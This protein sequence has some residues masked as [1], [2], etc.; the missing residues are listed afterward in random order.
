MCR[1]HKNMALFVIYVAVSLVGATIGLLHPKAILAATDTAIASL[2]ILSGLSLAVSSL[3][4]GVGRLGRNQPNDP[5][6][7]ENLSAK[8][9]Q[10]NSNIS[11]RQSY[12]IK[13]FLAAILLGLSFKVSYEMSSDSNT[14]IWLSALFSFCA[15]FSLLAAFHLPR[16]LSALHHRNRHFDIS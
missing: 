2:S 5:V 3:A 14:T 11:L 1:T 13:T 15:T 16:L 12:L 6:L 8:V 4:G 10:D 9:A 7:E